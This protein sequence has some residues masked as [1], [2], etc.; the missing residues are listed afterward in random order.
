MIDFP[1]KNLS[2]YADF[3]HD[4]RIIRRGKL[5][6]LKDNIRRFIKELKPYDLSE[7]ADE[8]LQR[9]IDVHD[10]NMFDLVNTY[11]ERYYHK[12]K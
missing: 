6:K 5:K 1:T 12:E 8:T 4:V 11:S 9:L 2:Y 7:I 10:L 3:T